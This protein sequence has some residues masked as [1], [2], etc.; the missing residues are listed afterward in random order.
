VGGLDQTGEFGSRNE[1]DIS[2][3]FASNDDGLLL[4]DYL[5]QKAG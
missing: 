2:R 1:R 3:P 5:V 4:V